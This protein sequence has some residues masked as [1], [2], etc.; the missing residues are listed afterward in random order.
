M[1]L[2]SH[3]PSWYEVMGAAAAVAALANLTDRTILLALSFRTANA[4]AVL[5]RNE[6][7]Q[8]HYKDA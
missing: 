5:G 1:S 6:C 8:V 7:V 2:H 3:A 4:R